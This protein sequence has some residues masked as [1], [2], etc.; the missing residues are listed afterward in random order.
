MQ[1]FMNVNIVSVHLKDHLIGTLSVK[2]LLI[3]FMTINHPLVCEE[4]EAQQFDFV[5]NPCPCYAV[6]SFF[7]AFCLFVLLVHISPYLY[8]HKV[9]FNSF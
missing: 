6:H 7:F 1:I 8:L 5:L 4:L 2:Q 3:F 9:D